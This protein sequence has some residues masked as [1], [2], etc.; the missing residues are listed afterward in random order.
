V[1]VQNPGQLTQLALHKI[2][3]LRLGANTR[4][5]ILSRTNQP[6]PN[7]SNRVIMLIFVMLERMI[8]RE[9]I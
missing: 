7:L 6:V 9:E 2:D 8:R 4:L 3:S 1:R 5:Q